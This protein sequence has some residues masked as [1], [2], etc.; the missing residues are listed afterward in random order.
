LEKEIKE[1]DEQIENFTS[2]KLA[3][4]FMTSALLESTPFISEVFMRSSFKTYAE[5]KAKTKYEN[6]PEGELKNY[7]NDYQN[8]LRTTKKDE[9]DFA[10]EGYLSLQKIIAQ[11]FEEAK[12]V[13]DASVNDE[14]VKSLL[15]DHTLSTT[16]LNMLELDDDAW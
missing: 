4:L 14:F 11:N 6:I 13:A 1:L 12:A 2:G 10:V 16:T 3:P 5:S 9:L 7:W 15:R 8:Y